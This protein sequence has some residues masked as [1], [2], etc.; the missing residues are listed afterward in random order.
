MDDEMMESV[1]RRR[2][3][4]GWGHLSGR[5]FILFLEIDMPVWYDHYSMFHG[6]T[7]GEELPAERGIVGPG[8]IFMCMILRPPFLPKG[9]GRLGGDVLDSM[10]PA[11]QG[12]HFNIL[13]RMAWPGI[14]SG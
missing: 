8:F 1:T 12:W 5:V 11:R 9:W 10:W 4:S 14:G 2:S 13:V 3:R 7:G 6:V